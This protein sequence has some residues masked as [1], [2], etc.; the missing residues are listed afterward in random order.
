LVIGGSN[1]TELASDT[2]IEND[3]TITGTLTVG[4]GKTATW[5]SDGEYSN[6]GTIDG[7]GTFEISPTVDYSLTL[8]T[9]ECPLLIGG[10]NITE[11]ASDTTIQN[12]V[13]V[14]G[15]LIDDEYTT[16][17]TDD[18]TLDF[19]TES[20]LYN[21]TVQSGVT[22]TFVADIPAFRVINSG[23]YDGGGFVEPMPEF[24][25]VPEEN[26]D[27]GSVW[28]YTWDQIYWDTF[29]VE[30]MPGWMIYEE[31]THTFK[32]MPNATGFFSFS[33]SLTW[34]NMTTYQNITIFVAYTPTV[35]MPW[36]TTTM[37]LI[38][39]VVLGFG[40]LILGLVFQMHYLTFFS[41]LIWLFS[42]LGVYA[43]IN[44]GWTVLSI[45]LGMMLMMI[46]GAKIAGE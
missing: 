8:G 30:T 5:E 42:A 25:T 1:I 6:T 3:V 17:F 37:S 40:C 32:A 7:T 28:L 12:D 26:V 9:I 35:D 2:N 38:L 45:A 15:T 33:I 21:V 43:D 31:D 14:T 44:I 11:L 36:F 10:S 24:T 18:S 34:E 19:S 23:T 20:Y 27:V 46:G 41:G 22:V 29:T 39:S 16:T 4:A 13:T